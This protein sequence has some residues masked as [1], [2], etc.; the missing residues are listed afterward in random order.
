MNAVHGQ[1]A[2]QVADQVTP[3]ESMPKQVSYQ[4][5]GSK[6]ASPCLLIELCQLNAKANSQGPSKRSEWMRAPDNEGQE[7]IQGSC[8]QHVAAVENHP[9]GHEWP[10]PGSG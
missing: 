8:P 7:A 6:L 1:G 10:C 2:E 5:N 9:R 4:G 3:E